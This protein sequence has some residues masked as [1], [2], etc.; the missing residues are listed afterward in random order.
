MPYVDLVSP[1]LT[2]VRI[3][4]RDMG[5][6]AAQLLLD[7]IAHAVVKNEHIVLAPQLIVRGSTA[8]PRV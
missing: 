1:P 5:E 2:T 6:A 8:A 7:R 3:A 4:Q